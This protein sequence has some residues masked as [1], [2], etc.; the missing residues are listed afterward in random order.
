METQ[1]N[2]SLVSI[3]EN[4]ESQRLNNEQMTYQFMSYAYFNALQAQLMP[5]FM[6]PAIFGGFWND[7]YIF[8]KIEFWEKLS[9]TSLLR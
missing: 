2:T 3:E 6:L 4:A 8:R 7:D 1:G 5:N 9:D